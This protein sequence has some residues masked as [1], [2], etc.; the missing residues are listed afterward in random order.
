M[1]LNHVVLLVGGVGGAKLAHGLARLLPPDSLTVIV[2]TGDDFWHYGLRVCPDLDT[3]MYTLGGLV[4]KSNGWGIGGDTRHMLAAR[5][6]YGEDTWFGLGDQDVATHLLRT[7]MWHEGKRLTEITQLLT[8]RLGIS[9]QIVPMTD[10]PVR[11]MIDTVEHGELEF[12]TYFVRYRWQPTV[13]AIRLDGIEA[14]AVSPEARTALERADLI[15]VGPSN[16]WLSIA[17]ILSVPGMRDLITQRQVP[18]VAVSPI[19]QGQAV[20]GPAAKLMAELNYDVSAQAVAEYYGDVITG[21]VYDERD[22]SLNLNHKQ[23]TSFDTIMVDDEDR[24]VLAR[25]ILAWIE[26]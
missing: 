12:Q 5:Q 14:A 26:E 3:V 15:F 10:A 16:P 24:V 25:K 9:H 4:D 21:Y 2:N 8:K 23:V 13:K 6:R 18:R 11:T 22:S 17:P 19:I 20:K 1:A 7:Q